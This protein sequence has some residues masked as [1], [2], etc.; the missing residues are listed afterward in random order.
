[1]PCTVAPP[2]SRVGRPP[3]PRPPLRPKRGE[4]EDA[5]A[6][7]LDQDLHEAP[8]LGQGPGP[9]YGYPPYGQYAYGTPYGY[10]PPKS[11]NGMAVASLVT[12]IAGVLTLFCYGVGIIAG[13]VGAILGHVARRRIRESGQDGAGLALS[14]IIIGWIATG[15]GILGVIGLVVALQSS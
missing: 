11:T 7:R 10:A 8:R 3:S 14:G 2:R 6:L 15:L 4:P 9:Q 1:M 12:S 5:V 13:I